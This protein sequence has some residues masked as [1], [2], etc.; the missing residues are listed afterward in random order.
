MRVGDERNAERSRSRREA[1]VDRAF[2][3]RSSLLDDRALFHWPLPRFSDSVLFGARPRANNRPDSAL[4]VVRWHNTSDRICGTVIIT[5]YPG[6]V[7]TIHLSTGQ[8]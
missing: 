5:I 2:N 3:E 7:V 1:S 6:I 8:R 4:A